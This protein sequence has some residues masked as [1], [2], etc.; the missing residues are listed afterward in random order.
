MQKH[1]I[2]KK[3]E[4]FESW[5]R[6]FSPLRKCQEKIQGN[7]YAKNFIKSHDFIKYKRVDKQIFEAINYLK[8][9]CQI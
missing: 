6:K 4:P 5:V 8:I 9:I 2:I 3:K 1:E 7:A